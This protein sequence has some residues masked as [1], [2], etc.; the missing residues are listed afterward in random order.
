MG[1]EKY[2]AQAA[3]KTLVSITKNKQRAADYLIKYELKDYFGQNIP[4][5]DKE[6]MKS[7]LEKQ[8]DLAMKKYD[9]ELNG[10]LRKAGSKGSMWLDVANQIYGYVSKT[11]VAYVGGLSTALFTGKTLLEVPALYRYAK[12]SKDWYGVGNYLALKPL[13]WL[14]PVVGPALESGAF[15]RMVMKGIIK[16]AKYNFIKEHGDYIP[17][18][19]KLKTPLADII[20]FPQPEKALAA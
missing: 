4:E 3:E 5:Q 9:A 17:V 13:R 12:K 11:P 14:T 10:L 7:G 8:L 18:K 1:L 15:E 16:E 2:L 19:E 6:R 20:Y